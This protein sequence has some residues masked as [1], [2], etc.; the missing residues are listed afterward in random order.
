MN[1]DKCNCHGENHEKS[2]GCNGNDQ[3]KNCG[4]Q[5]EHKTCGCESH[6]NQSGCTHEI[7]NEGCNDF[8]SVPVTYDAAE[9]CEKHEK[10]EGNN[11][12]CS[13]HK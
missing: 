8:D 2:C 12:W 3:H 1:N 5:D 6:V 9:S 7:K 10:C 13:T 11:Q 4:C